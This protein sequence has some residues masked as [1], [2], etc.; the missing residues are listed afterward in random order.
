MEFKF[1]TITYPPLKKAGV[2]SHLIYFPC[3]FAGILLLMGCARFFDSA[4]YVTAMMDALYK[5][6]YGSYAEFTDISTAEASQ[7]RSQWLS[8]ATDSFIT[9]MG[10]G[11]PSEEMRDRITELL[12][13][14]YANARYEVSD[15]E[16]G[17]VQITVWPM[18]LVIDNYDALKDYVNGFNEKNDAFAFASLSEQEFYDTYL[19]G[20]LSI[21][22]S[23]LAEL[24]Y[25]DPVQLNVIIQQG[26]DGLYTLDSKT[27]YN[28]QENIL[29][30]PEVDQQ[31]SKNIEEQK[32]NADTAGN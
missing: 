12:K 15:D 13:K 27:L 19:D 7:Y 3:L 22:E 4:G 14:I 16:N 17:N 2:I 18:D 1:K 9:I 11:E 25:K 6:D 28:I 21:L 8:T 31:P 26:E 20:I 32:N 23:H 29:W 24:S 30:W 10:S 5:G